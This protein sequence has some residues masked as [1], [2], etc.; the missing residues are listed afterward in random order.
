VLLMAAARGRADHGTQ[1][2]GHGDRI[3]RIG[4]GV[5]VKLP[6]AIPPDGD[7]LMLLAVTFSAFTVFGRRP[8]RRSVP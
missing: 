6:G 5:Q 8:R 1:A 3:G 7:L 2:G 4:A